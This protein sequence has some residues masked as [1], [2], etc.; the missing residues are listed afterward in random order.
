MTIECSW[1]LCPT[2]GMYVVTSMPLVSRTR[3]TLR[4]AE[5]GFLGVWVKT[6]TQTPRFCGL[7]CKAGLLV[8]LTIFLR[9]ARTSWLIVGISGFSQ[10][11]NER[12]GES[13]NDNQQF[14]NSPIRQMTTAPPQR[15]APL[16]P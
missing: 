14:R 5:F 1:R 11:V 10:L 4:S 2:P 13:V 12:G 6:R 3:A 16:F 9:P 7:F 15:R 8:L